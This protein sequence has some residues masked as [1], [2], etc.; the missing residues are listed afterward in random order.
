MSGRDPCRGHIEVEIDDV[1]V[2]ECRDDGLRGDEASEADVT[3]TDPPGA[4][5]ANVRV[6][7]A[8][9]RGTEFGAC[10]VAVRSW[11]DFQLIHS[12]LRRFLALNLR[13]APAGLP[14]STL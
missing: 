6:G 13:I 9:L 7:E 10:R 5:C 14:K 8:R 3:R 11:A 2:V 1:G 12:L 4:G